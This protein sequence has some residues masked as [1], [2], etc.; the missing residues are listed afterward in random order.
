MSVLFS[1]VHAKRDVARVVAAADTLAAKKDLSG[2][3]LYDVA[4]VY[5]LAAAAAKGQPN[6]EYASRA[7]AVLQLPAVLSE[8]RSNARLLKHARSTDHDLDALR[9]N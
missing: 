6:E 1:C 3:M 9:A 7:M 5:A 2:L 4:C 8:M